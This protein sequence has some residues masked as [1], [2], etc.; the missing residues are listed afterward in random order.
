M[1]HFTT[2]KHIRLS[3]IMNVYCEE[4]GLAFSKVKFNFDGRTINEIDTPTSLNLVDGDTIEVFQ[5]QNGS[6]YF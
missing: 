4:S 6:G 2:K 3:K 1:F 5:W